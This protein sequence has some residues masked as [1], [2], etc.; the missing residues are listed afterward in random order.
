MPFEVATLLGKS[1]DWAK[2]SLLNNKLLTH[3][4][5]I[6]TYISTINPNKILA[7]PSCTKTTKYQNTKVTNWDHFLW[8]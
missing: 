4:H 5:C 6:S 2:L 8:F 1:V 3:S 7:I